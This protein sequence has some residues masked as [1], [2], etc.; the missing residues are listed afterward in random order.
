MIAWNVGLKG[1]RWSV[2]LVLAAAA[3][4]SRGQSPEL[5]IQKA[6]DVSGMKGTP[7]FPIAG[8]AT[9]DGAP[10]EFTEPRKR[11]IGMLYDPEKPDLPIG[12]R[13][14][15]IVGTDGKFIFSE[16]GIAPGHYVLVFAVLKR[17]GQ[18]NFTG[19]DELGNL[20]NDP[21]VN[22]KNPEFVIDHQAPGKKD[23]QIDLQVSGKPPVTTPGPHAMTKVKY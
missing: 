14:R 6:Y 10:P 13:P 11:L 17:K 7:L 22:A 12:T 4:C 18:R 20:Y 21:D 9:I 15:V 3:G 5:R 23:Y 16:D 19:P 2:L 8:A 1:W